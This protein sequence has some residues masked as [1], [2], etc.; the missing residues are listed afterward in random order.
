MTTKKITLHLEADSIGDL[1]AQIDSILGGIR[2]LAVT[3]VEPSPLLSADPTVNFPDDNTTQLPPAP[4]APKTRGRPPKAAKAAE[5]PAQPAPAETPQAQP[6][7]APAP[8]SAPNGAAAPNLPALKTLVT[9][10]TAAVRM[11]Q[12]GEFDPAILSLLGPFKEATGLEFVMNATE[13]HR[14]ALYAL[15]QQAGVPLPS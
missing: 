1:L 7:P 14:A 12:K 13:E 15:V 5:A 2:P 11:A 9:A 10:V 3:T 8:A 4:P 6:V